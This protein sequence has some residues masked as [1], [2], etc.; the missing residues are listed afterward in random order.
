MCKCKGKAPG[1]KKD[2]GGG[3]QRA[4]SMKWGSQNADKG[5]KGFAWVGETPP[6]FS[7][8]RQMLVGGVEF[9]GG[10]VKEVDLIAPV[11]S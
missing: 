7:R 1:E 5:F 8:G 11:F 10:E 2:T 9:G 6:H 3:G 4:K